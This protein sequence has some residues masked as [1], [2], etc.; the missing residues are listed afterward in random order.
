M[1][2]RSSGFCH[3][4]KYDTVIACVKRRGH[5]IDCRRQP[6][7]RFRAPAS[8][9]YA[10]FI[11]RCSPKDLHL[12]TMA[13]RRDDA[14]IESYDIA[15]GASLRQAMMMLLHELAARLH[16]LSAM[17]YCPIPHHHHYYDDCSTIE[18]RIPYTASLLFI[19]IEVLSLLAHG[20]CLSVLLAAALFY[21]ISLIAA[22]QCLC[23]TF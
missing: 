13:I 10:N 23:A 20:F 12:L 17:F 16:S 21:A 22:S 1:A 8:A 6:P 3:S 4:L 14:L 2:K 9:R 5:S 7:R 11:S 18:R 15:T 19:A